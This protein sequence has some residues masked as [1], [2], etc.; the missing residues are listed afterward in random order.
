MATE[1]TE[2]SNATTTTTEGQD[3]G[4]KLIPE[5]RLTGLAKQL[6]ET[7]AALESLKANQEQATRKAEEEAARK[8]G[9]LD[10]LLA[11]REAELQAEKSARITAERRHS[12]ASAGLSGVVAL[13]LLAEYGTLK[14]PPA[15]DE[16]LTA[17]AKEEDV[18]RIVNAHRGTATPPMVGGVP[19]RAAGRNADELHAAALKAAREGKPEEAKKLMAEW[20]KAAAAASGA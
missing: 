17:R 8:A 20:A 4:E 13:G 7:K 2:T 16:W 18:A 1:T 10:K 9:E 5:S 14:E 3:S 15:F 11:I 12:L 6:A 19:G